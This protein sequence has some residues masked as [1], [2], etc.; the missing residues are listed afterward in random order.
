[1]SRFLF[2][3][4]AEASFDADE[5]I[6]TLE[7]RAAPRE[8]PAGADITMRVIFSPVKVALSAWVQH[9]VQVGSTGAYFDLTATVGKFTS[10]TREENE[11][12]GEYET[13]SK[14]GARIR[15]GLEAAGLAAG[16]DA[17]GAGAEREAKAACLAPARAL[18]TVK[19]IHSGHL[20]WTYH[21]GRG[22]QRISDYLDLALSL[23]A[24]CEWERPVSGTI[25]ARATLHDI[26]FF[27]LKRRELDWFKSA[28][29]RWKL[30]VHKAMPVLP[31]LIQRL[32]VQ[33]IEEAHHV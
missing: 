11:A 8:E 23:N 29:L 1:M 33:D 24:L 20:R 3:T 15:A 26:L 22:E 7:T 9:A 2:R 5:S 12:I 18:L 13:V 17:A 4:V 16:V 30:D 28:W 6:L 32:E 19:E 21:L 25:E 10:W 31:L 14:S 27:D